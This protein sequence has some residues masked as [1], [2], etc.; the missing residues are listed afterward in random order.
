MFGFALDTGKD[1]EIIS[2][3]ENVKNIEGS[4]FIVYKK[5][6]LI[7]VHNVSSIKYA[8]EKSLKTYENNGFIYILDQQKKIV[9]GTFISNIKIIKSKRNNITLCGMVWCQP[10]GYQKAW[11]M[12]VNN[13]II[14]KD[15]WKT[16]KKNELQGWLVYALNSN[17]CNIKKDNIK[18][19]LD[20]NLFHNVDSFFCALG[21]EVNGPGGYFGRNLYALDDCLRGDFGV[22]SISEFTWINH[23]RSKKLFKTQFIEIINIFEKYDV[24]VLLS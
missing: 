22:K 17:E 11:H 2:F 9:S 21:E 13:E 19:E 20:G 3:I 18:I 12:K 24:K 1:P 8:I 23:R 5:I 6:R 14:E 4:S 16:F 7:N 10:K 15:I